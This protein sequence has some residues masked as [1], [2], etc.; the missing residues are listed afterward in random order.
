MIFVDTKFKNIQKIQKIQK[1]KKN[2]TYLFMREKCSAFIL[3]KRKIA[4]KFLQEIYRKQN[5]E[6]NNNH[7]VD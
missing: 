5:V 1:E 7:N 6:I 3:R 2:A 4:P